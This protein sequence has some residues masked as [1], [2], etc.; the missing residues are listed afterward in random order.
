M[1]SVGRKISIN[2][3]DKSDVKIDKLINIQN[4]N[5]E[6]SIGYGATLNIGNYETLRVDIKISQKCDSKNKEK[7]FKELKED[8]MSKIKKECVELRKAG[9]M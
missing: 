9:G 2:K 1:K 6:I 5:M 3:M 8:V 4:D 7:V